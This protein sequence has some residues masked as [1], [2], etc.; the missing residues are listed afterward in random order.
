MRHLVNAYEVEAGTV[1]FAG[2]TVSLDGN[3]YLKLYLSAS[4]VVFHE[5]ALYQVYL[6]L[7]LPLLSIV[8]PRSRAVSTTLTADDNTGTCRMSTRSIWNLDPSHS[9]WVLAGFSRSR[10]AV[11]QSP[12]SDRQRRVNRATADDA[13]LTGVAV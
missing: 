11:I 3:L 13:R 10:L 6:P 7:P 2:N 5:E 8:T 9:T 4:E 1:K 12:T